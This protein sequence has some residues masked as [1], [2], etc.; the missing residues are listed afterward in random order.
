M[1]R[2]WIAA[3]CFYLAS[4]AAQAQMMPD[5]VNAGPPPASGYVGPGDVVSGATGWYGLRAYS[6]AYAAAQGKAVNLRRASDNTQCDFDVATTGAL[7]NSD[8]GCSLG[9]GLTLAAFAAQDATAT[10]TIA[11]T[12]ATCTGGSSVPHANS[13]LTGAGVPQPCYATAAGS[14]TSASFTVALAGNGAVSPCGTIGSGITITF[15]YGLLVTELYDQTGNSNHVVQATAGNQ[16]QLL[17]SCINSLPCASNPSGSTNKVL[18]ATITSIG[19]GSMA[20]VAQR[21]YN[22]TVTQTTIGKSNTATFNFTTTANTIGISG[23][24]Q[25][26]GSVAD[27]S[28]HAMQANYTPSSRVCADGTCSSTSTVAGPAAGTGLGVMGT[29]AGSA[30]LQGFEGEAGF[31]ATTFF[32]T[33]QIASLCHNQSAYWGTTPAC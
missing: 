1:T 9:G 14:G 6:A 31:W 26:L 5:I 24:A 11:T 20:A 33:G 7:G 29:A 12:T 4:L 17:P 30:A 25:T 28:P 22:F 23:T 18:T 3:L 2:R 16:P 13:T 19:N 21:N 8:A 15:T 10:C 32:T 27:L